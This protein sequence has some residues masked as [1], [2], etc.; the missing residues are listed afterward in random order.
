MPD[1]TPARLSDDHLHRI[2]HDPT[3]CTDGWHRSMAA[4]LIALRARHSQLEAQ[5]PTL[6]YAAVD[7]RARDR[8]PQ[9]VLLGPWDDE[10]SAR[11]AWGDTEGVVLAELSVL[12]AQ[13]GRIDA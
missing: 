3:M 10:K 2:V 4:E 12:P 6:G 9:P 7:L 11:E 1:Q 5:R 13:E 8:R